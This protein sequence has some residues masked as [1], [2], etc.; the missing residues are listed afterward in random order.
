MQLWQ[1]FGDKVMQRC[2]NFH[3]SWTTTIHQQWRSV[4]FSF[5]SSSLR[6]GRLAFSKQFI[7][8]IHPLFPAQG[9]FYLK[10]NFAIHEGKS[11]MQLMLRKTRN[12]GIFSWSPVHIGAVMRN[13]PALMLSLRGTDPIKIYF[14]A[15]RIVGH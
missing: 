4:D 11:Q 5:F 10:M 9:C 15:G 14:F 3:T 6:F 13:A 2:S 1:V 7:K 8:T 12:D